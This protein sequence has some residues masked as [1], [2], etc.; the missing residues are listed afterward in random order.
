[1][2]NGQKKEIDKNLISIL[3]SVQWMDNVKTHPNAVIYHRMAGNILVKSCIAVP[4]SRILGAILQ[5]F[6]AQFLSHSQGYYLG[7]LSCTIIVGIWE[8]KELYE[9]WPK[10]RN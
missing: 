5:R 7:I 10:K 3:V 1:M 8:I 2:N 4:S 6:C 9:Q